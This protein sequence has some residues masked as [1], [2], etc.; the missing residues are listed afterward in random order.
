[1]PAL[2]FVDY[3]FVLLKKVYPKTKVRP[4][5]LDSPRS[6]SADFVLAS[7]LSFLEW[8]RLLLVLAPVFLDD[9]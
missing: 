9:G 5:E 1:M 6:S 2:K 7:D 3:K 8:F 4:C